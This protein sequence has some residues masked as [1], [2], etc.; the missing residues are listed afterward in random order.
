MNFRQSLTDAR[1]GLR[2]TTGRSILTFLVFLAISTVFWFLLALND[3][4]QQDYRLQVRL[5]DFPKDLTVISGYYPVLNVTVKDKGSSLSKF[6]WGGQPILKL[7]YE[8]FAH[9]RPN[10]L[11]LSQ[12]QLNSQLRSIFG[13]SSTIVGLRP[14]S[15]DLYYTTEPGI[16]VP[17]TVNAAVSTA[18]QYIAFGAPQVLPDTV[19]LFSNSAER[20]DVRSLSTA[21]IT[22]ANLTDTASVEVRLDIPPLMRAVPSTVK[23]IFP[24]EPLVSRTRTLP[25]EA[26]NVPKGSHLVT[27]PSVVEFTHL[28]PK[29]QYSS[30]DHPIKAFV[31]FREISHDRP[32]L[33]VTLT[34]LPT[35]YRSTSISPEEVEFVIEED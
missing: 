26:L 21:P 6:A 10:H 24:V 3:E 27:F 19:M 28:L 31:D 16:P 35:H 18:T 8:D 1:E 11:L 23:V 13:T 5:T 33:P 2:S 14:D 17:V 20:F 22:L 15:L 25:V 32:T 34:I 12:S 7:H 29:S 9:P 30:D 4:V